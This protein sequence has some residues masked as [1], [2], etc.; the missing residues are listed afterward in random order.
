[1]VRWDECRSYVVACNRDSTACKVEETVETNAY[2]L[3]NSDATAKNARHH[4]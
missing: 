1:M 2:G 4:R 3:Q